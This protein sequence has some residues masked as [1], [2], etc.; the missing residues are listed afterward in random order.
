MNDACCIEVL[1]SS[2][3]TTPPTSSSDTK[4]TNGTRAARVRR[5]GTTVSRAR[6]TAA[7]AI[8]GTRFLAWLIKALTRL[9]L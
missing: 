1:N 2:S 7:S 8:R 9:P 3:P 4:V 5:R 6:S